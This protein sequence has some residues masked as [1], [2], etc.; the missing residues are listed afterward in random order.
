MQERT[1]SVRRVFF[2]I[3]DIAIYIRNHRS[4]SGIQR[5][6]V[7]IIS[8]ITRQ[9]KPGAVHLAW[10]ADPKAPYL[11]CPASELLDALRRFD[12]V[13]LG[14][15]LGVPVAQQILQAAAEAASQ[16][17][18]AGRD[19]D[20]NDL[21]ILSDLGPMVLPTTPFP[22]K[23]QPG[24]VL[25]ALGRSWGQPHLEQSFRQAHANGIAVHLLVHDLIPMKLPHLANPGSSAAYYDWLS[26][27]SGYCDSYLANSQSTAADLRAFLGEL[28]AA[29]PIHATPLAQ[30]RLIAP[31]ARTVDPEIPPSHARA[32]AEART[33]ATLSLPVREAATLPFVLCVGTIE[34]RKNLWRLAQAWAQLAREAGPGLP[35]LILAG[36]RGWL[37]DGFLEML[38]RTG[39]IGGWVVHLDAPEDHELDYLYRHCLF[40]AKVSLYEGWGLPI[41]E[42][43]SYGKTGVVSQSSSM[44]EVGGDLVEYCD[45]NSIDDIAKACRK[46]MA[47]PKHRHGLEM[48]IAGS[49][50][51]SWADVGRDVLAALK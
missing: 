5:A 22:E 12:T 29:T 31:P 3:S 40:T 35:R 36:R 13:T 16:R 34:P 45:P 38:K 43:L 30:A 20:E 23:A 11:T 39:G 4:I 15:A 24:D 9:L 48:R 28:G 25:C 32:L 10:H 8:E 50:L 2:D 26:R 33:A 27:S 7:M 17:V 21:T 49:A 42:G 19:Q 37:T 14:R 6:S 51:R 47:D 18:I 1:G 46:L 41:G 44:P